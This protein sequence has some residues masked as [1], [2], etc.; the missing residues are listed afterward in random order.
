MSKSPT[1]ALSPPW[2]ALEIYVLYRQCEHLR[3]Q[4]PFQGGAPLADKIPASPD[5]RIE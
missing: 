2:A 1:G 5:S 4:Q 3:I